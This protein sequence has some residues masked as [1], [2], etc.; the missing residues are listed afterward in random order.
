[1]KA[2]QLYKSEQRKLDKLAETRYRLARCLREQRMG[3][4]AANLMLEAVARQTKENVA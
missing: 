2:Q 3:F 1:M 4:K